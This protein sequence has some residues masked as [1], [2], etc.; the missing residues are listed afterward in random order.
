MH[1]CLKMY[2]V[3]DKEYKYCTN[4][5]LD[6]CER[7]HDKFFTSGGLYIHLFPDTKVYLEQDM[8]IV[9]MNAEDQLYR[10]R[11]SRVIM[12]NCKL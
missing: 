6:K 5:Y 12:Y 3:R 2:K 9:Y 11:N 4:I 7:I 10:S 8:K 1:V